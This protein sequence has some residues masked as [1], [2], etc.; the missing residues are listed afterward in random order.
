VR[1]RRNEKIYETKR[2]RV[3]K[4]QKKEEK[5]RTGQNETKKYIKRNNEIR[6]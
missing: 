3:R 2:E 1:N 4:K 6:I 5:N